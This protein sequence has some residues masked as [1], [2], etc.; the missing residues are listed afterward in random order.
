MSS[1]KPE[2]SAKALANSWPIAATSRTGFAVEV[3]SGP[4]DTSGVVIPK[5]CADLSSAVTPTKFPTQML[6]P[7]AAR[8]NTSMLSPATSAFVRMDEN[9]TSCPPL[10]SSGLEVMTP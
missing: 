10:A 9:I 4:A 1:M 7:F 5:D 6:T 2:P 8:K 3:A